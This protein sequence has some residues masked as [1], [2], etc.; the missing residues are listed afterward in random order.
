MISAS[1]IAY[2]IGECLPMR[3]LV[4]IS[5]KVNSI[6]AL[7]ISDYHLSIILLATI[8]AFIWGIGFYFLHTE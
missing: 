6:L 2:V 5:E 7:P 1:L 3:I 8:L 4:R